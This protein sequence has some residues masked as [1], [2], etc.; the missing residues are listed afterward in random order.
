MNNSGICE[1]MKFTK[2]LKPNKERIILCCI[3]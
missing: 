3:I 2:N 1:K